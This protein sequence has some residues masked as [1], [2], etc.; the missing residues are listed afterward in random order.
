MMKAAIYTQFGGPIKIQQV[1]IPSL[2]DS[3][4]IVKVMA[5]GVCRSDWHGWKGHDDD[6]Q[7]HGLPFVP[8]HEFSGIVVSIGS[9]VSKIKVGDRVAVPFILSCGSCSECKL[10]KS[11]VCLDQNQ[12]GFTMV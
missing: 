2:D 5:T 9:H 6:I 3:S 11:T 12:P 4:C 7:N 10:G 8:G 1:K